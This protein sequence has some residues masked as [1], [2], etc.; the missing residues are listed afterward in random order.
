IEREVQE[1]QSAWRGFKKGKWMKEVNVRDFIDH[2]IAPYHG[3]E[4][5]LAGPT[6]NT[7]ALWDIVSD[8][9]RKE[10][11]AG[12]VLDVDVNTPSTIVS[13]APGYLDKEKE[14]IVGVQGSAP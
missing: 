2:N 9:T 4:A 7:V 8:L 10:R 1:V 3:D 14:Q 6:D 11:E 12:G 13:H 5:F